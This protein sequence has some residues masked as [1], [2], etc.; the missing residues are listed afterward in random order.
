M[1]YINRDGVLSPDEKKV[2]IDF[3]TRMIN[4]D[5]QEFFLCCSFKFDND[6]IAGLNT[7]V[8]EE[9]IF[10]W[11]CLNATQSLEKYKRTTHFCHEIVAILSRVLKECETVIKPVFEE[12]E[13]I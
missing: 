6:K 2:L 1:K 4:A 5:S 11:L 10:N 8:G 9:N 7:C 3:F 12:D 13:Q